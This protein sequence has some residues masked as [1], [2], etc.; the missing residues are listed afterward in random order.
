MNQT[1]LTT[2]K[3]ITRERDYSKTILT[4]FTVYFQ[5]GTYFFVRSLRLAFI[6]HWQ[7]TLLK[8]IFR[9][10]EAIGSQTDAIKITTNVRVMVALTGDDDGVSVS[11]SV[12]S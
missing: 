9:V 1:S 4:V 3:N 5:L 10:I 12:G 11:V 7:K 2:V 8:L 6:Y